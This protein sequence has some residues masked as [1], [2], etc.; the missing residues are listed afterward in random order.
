MSKLPDRGV[1]LAILTPVKVCKSLL[2]I[3]G[4]GGGGGIKKGMGVHTRDY[5]KIKIIIQNNKLVTTAAMIA[6]Y[7]SCE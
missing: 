2:N 7:P 5:Q 1:A 4:G 3:R 6:V